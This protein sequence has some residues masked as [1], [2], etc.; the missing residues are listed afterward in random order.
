MLA[1]YLWAD[2]WNT[3][4]TIK[5]SLITKFGKNLN[6]IL[7]SIKDF[8]DPESIKILT[9]YSGNVIYESSLVLFKFSEIT[10]GVK[11]SDCL[12]LILENPIQ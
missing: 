5:G 4:L 1:L 9:L 2:F 3:V 12:R 6:A 10:G 8:V 7:G 11:G